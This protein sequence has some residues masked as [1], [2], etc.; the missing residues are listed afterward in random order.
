M[1]FWSTYCFSCV[2]FFR[3][4]KWRDPSLSRRADDFGIT[5]FALAVAYAV[6]FGSWLP[7]WV[8]PGTN[9]R[10]YPVAFDS[11]AAKLQKPEARSIWHQANNLR[12][13]VRYLENTLQCQLFPRY[14]I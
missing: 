13:V 10:A 5:W 14:K 6:F 7:L 8:S 11:D 3:Q 4:L 9:K 12:S 1:S 2:V